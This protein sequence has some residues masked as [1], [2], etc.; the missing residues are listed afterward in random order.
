MLL[1]T[2]GKVVA[3]HSESLVGRGTVALVFIDDESDVLLYV[4][5]KVVRRPEGNALHLNLPRRDLGI[6]WGKLFQAN[7]ELKRTDAIKVNG[8][9]MGQWDLSL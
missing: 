3:Q 6:G 8:L 7:G 5:H 1:T 4:L 9:A 2:G